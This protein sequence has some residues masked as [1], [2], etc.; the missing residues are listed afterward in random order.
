MRETVEFGD[1]GSSEEE[2]LALLR[3]LSEAERETVRTILMRAIERPP[4]PVAATPVDLP[5]DAAG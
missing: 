2:R 1:E 5:P 3:R 4:T